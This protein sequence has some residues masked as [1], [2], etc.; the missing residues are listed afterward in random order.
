[1]KYT[2]AQ[3]NKLLK[4]LKDARE[5]ILF[6]E[7]NNDRFVAATVEDLES[8]RPD[9][10]YAAVQARL[11]VLEGQIRMV[12]HA[13]NQFNLTHT[14]EGF[15][16]T[17]DQMLVYIPQL[18]ERCS[19][20]DT[21]AD[22]P[23]KKRYNSRSNLIEYEYTNYDPEQVRAYYQAA[24]DLLNQAQLALDALNQSETMEIAL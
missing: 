10:D 3:A 14:V 15:D 18:S 5:S 20:L 9:Y 4:T 24:K 7:G 8:A 17:V 23:R 12:K 1:M 13:I 16:M 11:E 22:M 19:K 21:M 2:S 6:R